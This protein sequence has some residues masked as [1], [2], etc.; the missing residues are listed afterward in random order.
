MQEF[1]SAWI[2]PATLPGHKYIHPPGSSPN[3]VL[4]G[5]YRAFLM[6]A[7]SITDSIS[8]PSSLS[9]ELGGRVGNSKVVSGDQLPSRSHPESPPQNK[10]CSQCSY[11]RNSQGFQDFLCQELAETYMFFSIIS[12]PLTGEPGRHP[13][14][15]EHTDSNNF[16]KRQ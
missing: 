3:S 7:P 6:Q 13:M 1:L 12:Q 16:V 8:S 14:D 4:L 10:R 5:F 9:G 15:K 11:H 2:W